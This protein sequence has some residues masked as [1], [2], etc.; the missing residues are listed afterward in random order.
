VEPPNPWWGLHAAVVRDG[1][2]PEQALPLPEALEAYT[3][4][5]AWAAGLER[6]QGRLRPGM[7]A[8]LIVVSADP[9]RIPPD[10]LRDLEVLGTMVGGRWG[11]RR[12][13]ALLD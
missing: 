9:F 5:P 4:G 7:W 12:G 10:A 11:F 8:D 2:H 1:W 13:S 3:V 6:R